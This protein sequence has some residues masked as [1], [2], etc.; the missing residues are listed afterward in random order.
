MAFIQQLRF[1][2]APSGVE[3]ALSHRGLEQLG[4]RHLSDA[5]QGRMGGRPQGPDIP[6]KAQGVDTG[7]SLGEEGCLACVK[8]TQS[9][10]LL[11]AGAGFQQL[12]RTESLEYIPH[13]STGICAPLAFSKFST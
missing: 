5:S 9:I 1:E 3:D 6:S 7:P 10:K 11:A 4:G 8:L 2:R 12:T 13:L